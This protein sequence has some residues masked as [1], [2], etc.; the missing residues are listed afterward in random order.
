M[1]ALFTAN[2]SDEVRAALD[3]RLDAAMLP[4][5]TIHAQI[6]VDEA[7]DAV[8]LADPNAATYLEGTTALERARRACVYL[9]AALIAPVLPNMTAYQLG[10]ERFSWE[11]WDGLARAAQLRG[12]AAAALALNTQ[13]DG[14]VA[15][16]VQFQT[17]PGYRGR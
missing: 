3:L 6:F 9:V 12:L 15:P 11:K 2:S 1:P 14:L 8:L 7:T 17:A 13:A 5:E 16:M 4:D 10:S